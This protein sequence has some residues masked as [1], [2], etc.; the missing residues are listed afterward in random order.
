MDSIGGTTDPAAGTYNYADGTSVTF[1]AAGDTQ[2]GFSFL[3]WIITT[4]EGS[5]TSADNPLTFPVS[6]GST[7]T[8]QAIFQ[9]LQPI[10]ATSLPKDMS[11]AAIIGIL[12]A[13][14]GTT[15]PGPGTYAL[16]NANA[17]NLTAMPNNGWTFSHWVISGNTNVNHGNAPV[18]LE[19]KDNPYNVN[20]GYG[21]TYYYQPVFTQT[22]ASPSPSVPEF[23]VLAVL[24]LL[25]ALIPVVT[26]AK[27]RKLQ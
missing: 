7:Y 17:F 9:V 1:T 20:H 4:S 8:I 14:G 11:N 19:P 10:G 26:I 24:L 12:A 22:G 3:N 27:K 25:G 23:S 16:A 2:T 6:A 13:A 5:R 18:N 21:A 15:N